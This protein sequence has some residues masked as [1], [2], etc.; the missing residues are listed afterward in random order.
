[1]KAT[2]KALIAFAVVAMSSPVFADE[3][4]GLAS[5][6]L[7]G[8]VPFD[9]L[10]PFVAVGLELGYIPPAV[11]HRLAIVI[12]VDCRQPA[13]TGSASDPRVIGAATRGSSPSRSSP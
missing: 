6:K 11:D 13:R 8:V 2:M 5:A 9:D 1:M 3:P 4:A 10:S 7:G 12:D